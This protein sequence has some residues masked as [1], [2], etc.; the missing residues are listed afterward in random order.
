LG[1]LLWGQGRIEDAVEEY[2]KAIGLDPNYDIAHNNLGVIYLDNLGYVQEA[3]DCLTK[4]VQCNSRYALAHYNLGRAMAIKGD[5][6]EAARLLQV[7]LDLNAHTN[8]LDE[9]EIKMK[10]RELFD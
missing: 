6:V 2:R 5:K 9:N 10:I 1:F 8:E 4:A 7:A 3:I